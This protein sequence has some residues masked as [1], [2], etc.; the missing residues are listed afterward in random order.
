MQDICQ[1]IAAS[2]RR[3]WDNLLI[4]TS[5]LQPCICS[6]NPWVLFSS[7]EVCCWMSSSA[8]RAKSIR[9]PGFVLIEFLVVIS[10][11]SCCYTV[12]VVQ[13]KS[14]L[15]SLHCWFSEL[16]STSV[17][18]R[19]NLAM[20]YVEPVGLREQSIVGW[21]LSCVFQ[22]SVEQVLVDCKSNCKQFSFS[23]LGLS[24]WF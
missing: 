21:S 14:E 8:S 23:N 1:R 17:R 3:C 4:Y 24:C 15:E 19:H 7:V 10:S 20:G 12:Y 18:V 2:R 22:F 5:W 9:R 16:P 11:T 6:P 13:G